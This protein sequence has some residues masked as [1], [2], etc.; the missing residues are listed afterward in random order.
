MVCLFLLNFFALFFQ[1]YPTLFEK[2]TVYPSR[3]LFDFNEFSYIMN[4]L[5]ENDIKI[6]IHGVYEY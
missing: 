4:F 6:E 2:A 1:I 5:R 3:I